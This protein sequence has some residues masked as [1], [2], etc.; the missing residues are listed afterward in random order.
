MAVF[1]KNSE[2]DESKKGIGVLG[3]FRKSRS[4]L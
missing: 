2:Q 4:A 1:S 3:W